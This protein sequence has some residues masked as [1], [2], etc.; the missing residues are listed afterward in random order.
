MERRHALPSW[1]LDQA[2]SQLGT[3]W[4]WRGASVLLLGPPSVGAPM[5]LVVE[6]DEI[7]FTSRVARIRGRPGDRQLTVETMHHCYR[8]A[9][10][11]R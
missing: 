8:F 5:M 9:P 7:V 4:R 1:Q 11:R 6:P 10:A 3:A 2:A